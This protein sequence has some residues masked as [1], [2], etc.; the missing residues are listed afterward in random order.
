MCTDFALR[1]VVAGDRFIDELVG[2]SASE[3]R[4]HE[5]ESRPEDEVVHLCSDEEQ[6][7]HEQLLVLTAGSNCL[8]SVL[9]GLIHQIYSNY[10]FKIVM[11]RSDCLNLL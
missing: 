10:F 11:A 7:D 2:E 4:I 9:Y 1:E 6:E 3:E 8:E 5:D